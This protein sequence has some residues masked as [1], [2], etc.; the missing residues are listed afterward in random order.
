MLV[1]AASFVF[2]AAVIGT[3][4]EQQPDAA[5]TE[6]SETEPYLR[7]L[8]AGTTY[9]KRNRYLRASLAS[10]AIMNLV[11][12]AVQAV[13]IVYATRNLHLNPGQIGLAYGFGGFGG[14]AGAALAGVCA[15]A[16]G[17]G[18]TIALGALLYTVPFS[19]LAIATPGLWGLFVIATVEAVSGLGIMLFDVNNNSM[20][21][22]VTR[23]DMRSRVSGAYATVNYGARPLGAVIGG[24][25]ASWFGITP[26][27]IASGIGGL[28]AFGVVIASPIMKVKAIPDLRPEP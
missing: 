2:S 19:A 14:L 6:T 15:R 3:I 27:L 7:R 1:D 23:D 16:L 22:A 21:T 4:R 13:I 26:T 5:E 20:R 25:A 12:F 24:T 28:F 17:T 10:S 8:V 9:L 11:A 18:K